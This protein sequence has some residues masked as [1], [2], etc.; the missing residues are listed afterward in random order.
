MKNAHI[1][2]ILV[3]LLSCKEESI[4]SSSMFVNTKW[5]LVQTRQALSCFDFLRDFNWENYKIDGNVLTYEFTT[6]RVTEHYYCPKCLETTFIRDATYMDEDSLLKIDNVSL[7]ISGDRE[8]RILKIT[9]DTLIL[10]V[11]NVTGED[12]CEFKFARFK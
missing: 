5:D 11:S 7:I 10:G 2:I 1:F 8:T 12:Y 6:N 9:N 4:V 3:F